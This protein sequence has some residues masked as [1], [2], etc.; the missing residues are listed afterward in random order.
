MNLELQHLSADL[1]GLPD[2][3]KRLLSSQ[4]A[5]FGVHVPRKASEFEPLE[6]PLDRD[7]RAALTSRLSK[8]ILPFSPHVAV[9][10][11]LRAL[12]QPN[13]LIVLASTRP[14]PFG[15]TLSA[16]YATLHAVALAKT[17]SRTWNRAVVPMLW[18]DTDTACVDEQPG[19]WLRSNDHVMQHF[20][21]PAVADDEKTQAVRASIAHLLG[22]SEHIYEALD[23][24][25]PRH[26][27]C[28]GTAHARTTL[29]LLG[30]T[31][32]LVCLPD[33][34]RTDVSH[35]LAQIVS[36][37]PA[38]LLQ[39]GCNELQSQGFSTEEH[40]IDPVLVHRVEGNTS[41]PLHCGGD[42]FRYEHE[43]G[44]RTNVE[45]AAEI[46]QDPA[47]FVSGEA[48]LP[49]IQD[50]ALPL[51]ARI[52]NRD[53]LAGE[54]AINRMRAA[55][56]VGQTPVLPRLSCT[57]VDSFTRTSLA[58]LDLEVRDVCAS[59]RP[60]ER[61]APSEPLEIALEQF[62]ALSRETTSSLQRIARPLWELDPMLRPVSKRSATKIRR[63]LEELCAKAEHVLANHGGKF[64]RHQRLVNSVLRPHGQ[65]QEDVDNLLYWTA[66]FGFDWTL[67][68]LEELDPFAWEHLVVN[69][70]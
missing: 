32:I 24:L 64:Q 45:L 31:G 30:S 56:D 21:L 42:G 10:D 3:S 36:A 1:L 23:A 57:L 13:S 4:A 15:S 35:F 63:T 34:I 22:S 58:K 55:L 62:R 14:A 69:F 7:E 48:L 50:L 53:A 2:F 40:A 25:S 19:T 61:A 60:L 28:A 5:L 52:V 43:P 27:E 37:D 38:R 65:P 59:E 11:S 12:E 41:Q 67:E 26:G 44:S 29:N 39:E 9:L 16:L 33:W 49:L 46:V 20:R 70:P 51:A 17:L 54:A 47:G 66:H 6:D 8:A 18:I 68:L